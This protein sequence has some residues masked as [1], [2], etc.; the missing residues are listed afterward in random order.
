MTG[1]QLRRIAVAT[2]LALIGLIVTS[3]L[4]TWQYSRA[5]RDDIAREVWAAPTLP[6]EQV[7]VPREFVREQDF[8]RHVAVEGTLHLDRALATCG[9]SDGT[10]CWI[11]APA[12]LAGEPLATTLLLGAVPSPTLGDQL[13]ALRARGGEPVDVTGRLQPA[14]VMNTVAAIVRPTDVVPNID[15]NEL[16]M[17]WSTA[18]L[19]GYVVLDAPVTG[20]AIDAPLVLPPSGIT[21]RNLLY[22]WQW[23]AFAAF[24]LF[25]L[26]R[27]VIDVRRE[28]PSIAPSTE[29]EL[30]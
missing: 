17:R 22:A 24:V 14:E 30:P 20:S 3:A 29:E 27:Y 2:L 4:G 25:M 8:T 13:T 21:W 28:T 9:R 10:W 15:I 7:V 26:A 5:H 6:I 19:D 18:L 11:L 23:W 16:A 1:S 12:T